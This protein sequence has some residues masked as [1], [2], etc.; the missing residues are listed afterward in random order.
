MNK[1][2]KIA[3]LAGAVVF[4]YVLL[5]ALQPV[6]NALVATANASGTWT[7][8]ESTQAAILGWPIIVWFIP[9]LV[10]VVL[11]AVIWKSPGK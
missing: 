6:T 3:L 4:S 11:T 8:F 2:F 7:G 5:L 1:I 9:G 10:G